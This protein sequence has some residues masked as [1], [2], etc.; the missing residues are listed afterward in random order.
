MSSRARLLL[1]LVTA[2]ALAGGFVLAS[3]AA[4]EEGSS[5]PAATATSPEEADATT[6]AQTGSQQ[7]ETQAPASEKPA[8]PRIPTLVVEGG[9][10][11]DEARELTFAKGERVRFRVRSDVAEELHIH[12]Y[13]RYVDV[14]PGRTATVSFP[15]TIEGIFEIELHGAGVQLASLRVEP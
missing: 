8:A 12:G 11:R 2:L 1:V 14:A 10:P 7:T 5:T 13:D 3:Q 6:Q 15:A 9:R 4:Q